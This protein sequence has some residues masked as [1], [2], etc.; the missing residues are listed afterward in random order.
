MTPAGKV[1]I[2]YLRIRV[3]AHDLHER[4]YESLD[5]ASTLG[6]SIRQASH[7]VNLPKPQLPEMGGVPTWTEDAICTAEDTELFFPPHT[8]VKAQ[9]YKRQAMKICARC[10]VRAKCREMALVNC[11]STGVWGGE[12]FSKYVYEFDAMTGS[13][14]VSMREGDGS[15]PKVS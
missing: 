11:E 13:L 5:I 1:D 12:D 8:G 2:N 7:Y 14:R 3:K 10:P 15:L 4:G 6:I 9:N